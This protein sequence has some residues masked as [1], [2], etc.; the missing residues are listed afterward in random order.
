MERPESPVALDMYSA[1]GHP[2]GT[3]LITSPTVDEDAHLVASGK[4]R[5]HR[6]SLQ[7]GI[8]DGVAKM[9]SLATHSIENAM[10]AAPHRVGWQLSA[11]AF[12][13][14]K[15]DDLRQLRRGPLRD[16]YAQQNNMIDRIT[17]S[18]S[19]PEP[20]SFPVQLALRLSMLAN[21]CL[22]TAKVYASARSGSLAVI[23]STVESALDLV[24]GSVLL[25]AA[26]LA[27]KK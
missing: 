19:A 5:E 24:S 15:R 4:P 3:G 6:T 2:A 1:Q 14:S 27:S 23:G 8:V 12:L 22:F 11:D 21:V 26:W 13:K 20:D 9:A 16:F 18:P 17:A 10:A 7:S 25:V